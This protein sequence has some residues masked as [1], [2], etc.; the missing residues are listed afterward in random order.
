M[1]AAPNPKSD[2]KKLKSKSSS[3]RM[4]AGDLPRE[5][6]ILAIKSDNTCMSNRH[7]VQSS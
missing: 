1:D 2:T 4:A 3:S 6:D 7:L 5:E